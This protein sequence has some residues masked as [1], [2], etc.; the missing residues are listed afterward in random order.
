MLG[1]N[2]ISLDEIYNQKE[3]VKNGGKEIVGRIESIKFDGLNIKDITIKSDGKTKKY[4]VDFPNIVPMKDGQ[5]ELYGV[6]P[7]TKNFVAAD[8]EYRE[9]NYKFTTTKSG[10]VKGIVEVSK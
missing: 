5:Y 2:Y 3:Y 8:P 10:V 7:F 1:D 4:K 6:Y 9:K